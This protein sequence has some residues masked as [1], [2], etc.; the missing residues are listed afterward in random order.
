[1]GRLWPVGPELEIRRDAG[2]PLPQL[3]LGDVLSIIAGEEPGEKRDVEHALV[4][5]DE[6]IRFVG[7]DG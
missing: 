7:L 5:G 6:D 4:I 2:D 3:L 1:M